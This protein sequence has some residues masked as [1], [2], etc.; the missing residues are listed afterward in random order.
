M[1]NLLFVYNRKT[2]FEGTFLECSYSET[3]KSWPCFKFKC[4]HSS[5]SLDKTHFKSKVTQS[6]S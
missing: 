4:I 2:N 5:V 1:L 3:L 6:Y